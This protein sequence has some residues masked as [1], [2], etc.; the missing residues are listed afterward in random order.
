MGNNRLSFLTLI[1]FGVALSIGIL[2]N[3][4][5]RMV[6]PVGTV[7]IRT[8]MVESPEFNVRNVSSS[9]GTKRWFEITTAYDINVEWVDELEFVYYVYMETNIQDDRQML[10]THT[11][12]YRD[13]P[14]DRHMSKVYIHPDTYE[15]FVDRIVYTGVEIRY[16]GRP[17]AWST[18]E[19][20][21]RDDQWWEEA[22][23]AF[24]PVEG[25]IMHREDTPF[26]LI[27]IDDFPARK[28]D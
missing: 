10:W 27:N 9:R 3:A 2:A 26:G 23:R 5:D 25:N 18:E 4:R 24:P 8:D 28:I 21:R 7:R 16:R 11:V 13:I 20:R 22:R 1:I 15:R 12:S 17:I 6:N 19:S 14:R